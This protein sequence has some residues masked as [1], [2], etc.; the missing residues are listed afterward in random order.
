[1]EIE[2][3]AESGFRGNACRNNGASAAEW[4]DQSGGLRGAPA[5]RRGSASADGGTTNVVIM[6][7][8]V[9]EGGFA[10][11]MRPLGGRLVRTSLSGWDE[12]PGRDAGPN[13]HLLADAG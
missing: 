9:A 7:A 4:C 11:V 8:K 6:S 12:R 5:R 2:I 1:V 3:F 10:A 13:G